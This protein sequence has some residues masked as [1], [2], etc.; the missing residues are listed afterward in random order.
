MFLGEKFGGG[1]EKA[2]ARQLTNWKKKENYPEI[3]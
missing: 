2:G 1:G 3:H